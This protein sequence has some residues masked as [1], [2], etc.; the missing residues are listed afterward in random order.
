MVEGEPQEMV[1]GHDEESEPLV[2]Y[3]N[4]VAVA[5]TL[6]DFQINF[7]EAIV[8]GDQQTSSDLF[9]TIIMSPQHAKLFVKSLER[10]VQMYEESFG[11]IKL[12]EAA[13]ETIIKPLR[14]SPSPSASSSASPSSSNS[15]SP[16]ESAS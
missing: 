6:F 7:I 14:F 3:A 5:H 16:S 1:I 4:S 13:Y 12:P 11:E 8:R 15:P 10:N 2:G 9:A